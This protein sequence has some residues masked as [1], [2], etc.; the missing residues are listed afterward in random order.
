MARDANEHDKRPSHIAKLRADLKDLILRHLDTPYMSESCMDRIKTGN[1]YQSID[2]GDTTTC[3]FRRER[4]HLLDQI[5]F[6]GK[7]VLD[8]GSNLGEI[9]RAARMRGA[10]LV[11]GFES[12]PYFL[13]I[14]DLL[15]ALNGT[16]RVSFY[17]R[18]ITSPTV[19]TEAYDVVLALS[20]FVYI[21]SVLERIAHITD[22]LVLETHKLEGNLETTYL[23]PMA[24]YF[25]F[26]R[27]IGESEWGAPLDSS[28]KRAIIVFAKHGAALDEVLRPRLSSLSQTA[29]AHPPSVGVL[30]PSYS[31]SLIDVVRTVRWCDRFF[32][33]FVFNSP[34]DLLEA[35]ASTDCE[36][37][38][39]VKSGDLSE[40]FMSGCTYWTLYIKGYLQYRKSGEV[41]PHNVY[42]AYLT[43]YFGPEKRDPGLSKTLADSSAARARVLKRFHDFD[44][45]RAHA[46]DPQRL[47]E[48]ISPV[49]VTCRVAPTT[50]AKPIYLIGSDLPFRA[51]IDGYHRL[52]LARLFALDRLRCEIVQ[53]HGPRP[54]QLSS[55][56]GIRETRSTG[57]CGPSGHGA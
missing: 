22:L 41:D 26:H 8:L 30:P 14:A 55:E 48:H 51:S 35:I 33:T 39:M 43:T 28:V 47:L 10:Y 31:T 45:F 52:F 42:Y 49:K 4:G 7:R 34:G 27:I 29:V 1:H 20:V 36:V 44:Q 6:T 25:P 23:K 56:L 32:S 12:D 18:D 40:Y 2:L 16:S 3:G 15:N 17:L 21:R 19:Y 11:D 9:S 24:V 57:G 46:G 50:D 13:Q 53:Q 54:V 37:A 38:P 5:N